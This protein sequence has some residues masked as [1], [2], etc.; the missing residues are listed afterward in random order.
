MRA[1]T[2]LA[3]IL[4]LPPL[5]CGDDPPGD[6]APG[7]TTDD[8]TTEAPTTDGSTS[9]DTGSTVPDPTTGDATTGDDPTT[10][11]ETTTDPETT[12]DDT[13]GVPSE[14][15]PT[16]GAALEAWLMAGEYLDW[17]AESGVHPSTGPHFGG[18][19]TFVNDALFASLQA[20]ATEH[21]EGAAAVKELYG[22][23]DEIL[24]WS[25][26]V[27]VQADSAGGDGWY[28]YEGYQGD[29]YA[30]GIGAGICTGC[31]SG[32][33]DYVLTPFPLQ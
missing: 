11:A 6:D 26:E 16:D 12:S 10:T 17:P 4:L 1:S 7:S 27:K 5:A 15:P 32:G 14:P 19:R 22:A 8:A 33:T 25:V 21:P 30:D 31:H 29:V 24:G 13:T 9:A 28:W 18:V 23:G 2:A 3:L 20:G